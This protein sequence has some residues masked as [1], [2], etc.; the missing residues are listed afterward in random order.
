MSDE[1]EILKYMRQPHR[2]AC[3]QTE[4][5]T[6]KITDEELL[7][8]YRSK[9]FQDG[10]WKAFVESFDPETQKLLGGIEE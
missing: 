2:A 8:L 10:I 4:I 1:I 9:K 5:K 6:K 7:K 3:K